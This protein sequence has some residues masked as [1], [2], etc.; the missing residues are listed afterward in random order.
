MG[1]AC[2]R[3]G[4][5]AHYRWAWSG[6]VCERQR[7]NGDKTNER[8]IVQNGSE[9]TKTVEETNDDDADDAPF[10]C[11]VPN[12]KCSA[13]KWATVPGKFSHAINTS[14][15]EHD[16]GEKGFDTGCRFF[17]FNLWL[18]SHYRCV[19][20]IAGLRLW[21]CRHSRPVFTDPDPRMSRTHTHT[22]STYGLLSSPQ[23]R[24]WKKSADCLF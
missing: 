1:F 16:G 4:A 3:R 2:R 12:H 22:H 10:S 15:H 19:C 6:C 5:N 7:H 23:S 8:E 17:S 20:A 21:L 11:S 13:M 9:K 18:G 24:R 14:A